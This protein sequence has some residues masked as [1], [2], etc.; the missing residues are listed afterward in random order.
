MSVKVFLFFYQGMDKRAL[1]HEILPSIGS[2]LK[3]Q[4]LFTE[5]QDQL[6]SV[7]DR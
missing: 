2:N 4:R 1:L 6:E 7:E 5:Y 3:L